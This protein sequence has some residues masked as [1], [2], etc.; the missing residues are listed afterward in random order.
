MNPEQIRAKIRWHAA[1][2]EAERHTIG[3]ETVWSVI[4]GI[5]DAW[6]PGLPVKQRVANRRQILTYLFG[7]D[8]TKLLSDFQIAAVHKWL[9]AGGATHDEI[10]AMLRAALVEAGQ[11]EFSLPL[12][13]GVTQ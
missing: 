7:V 11:V 5:E 1:R 4:A 2:Y 13:K 9:T 3:R 8:S 12:E 10:R 6:R